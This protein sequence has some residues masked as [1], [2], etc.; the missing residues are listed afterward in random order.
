MSK[1]VI[2]VWNEMNDRLT[3]FVNQKV[4]DSDITKDI[5]QDVF[6]KVFSKI[7]TLKN[8]E[9]LI[10]WIYQ[11]TRNE[12]ISHFRK[13]QYNNSTQE[14]QSEEETEEPLTSEVAECLHPLINSLPDKYKEALIL[15]DIENIP[16]KEIAKRL[17]ISYSGAKSRVQRGREMLRLAYEKCCTISTDAYG[18]VIDY[19]RKNKKDC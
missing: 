3:K 8:K 19:Q 6:L 17:N 9:K 4:N 10:S 14:I 11:I 5:V 7:E 16:Q 1:E 13:I 12:I 2:E 18:D 15:A